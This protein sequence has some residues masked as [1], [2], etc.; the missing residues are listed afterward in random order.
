MAKE[1]KKR[2][3]K[4][5]FWD[6]SYKA[7]KRMCQHNGEQIFKALVTG[8]NE[9]GEVRIQ[10]FVHTDSHDQMMCVLEAFKATN[11]TLGI[12]D[13]KYFVTDNPTADAAFVT[14]VFGS[15]QKQQQKLDD[16]CTDIPLTPSSIDYSRNEVKVLSTDQEVNLAITAM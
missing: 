15:L 5:I 14:S 7:P 16:Q 8:M 11:K 4:F 12:E 6:A 2:P 1:V 10:F 13:P 3:V 9:L